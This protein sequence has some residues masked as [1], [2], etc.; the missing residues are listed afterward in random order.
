MSFHHWVHCVLNLIS[1]HM[2]YLSLYMKGLYQFFYYNSIYKG[3]S[4]LFYWIHYNK[5]SGLNRPILQIQNQIILC[6]IQQS[7]AIVD[8]TLNRWA[9]GFQLKFNH[10]FFLL[11]IFLSFLFLNI[12]FVLCVHT[13]TLVL[14]FARGHSSV[15]RK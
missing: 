6:F 14:R 15:I 13:I 11:S 9:S 12:S 3:S 8:P 1:Y 4:K 2:H 5:Q 7:K 10:H